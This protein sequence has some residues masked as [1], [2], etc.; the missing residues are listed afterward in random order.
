[1]T[2]K[3]WKGFSKRRNSTKQP[4]AT[5]TA[6]L[7]CRLKDNTSLHDPVLEIATNDFG[8]EY[9]YISDVGKYYFVHDV[10]SV[11]N[12]LCEYHLVEDTMA[13]E[14]TAIGATKAHIAYSSTGYNAKV[15]DPRIT[16]RNHKTILKSG[17]AT[18]GNAYRVFSPSDPGHFILTI[19]YGNDQNHPVS[20]D[21][22]TGVSISYFLSYQDIQNFAAYLSSNISAL[23]QYFNGTG[24]NCV[25]N[26][27]WVPYDLIGTK[28]S[29]HGT[30]IDGNNEIIAYYDTR[31]RIGD[32]TSN[33]DHLSLDARILSGMPRYTNTIQVPCHLQPLTANDF[34]ASEPYTTGNIYLP[35]VGTVN[36]NMSDWQDSE[37]INVEYTIEYATGNMR[38][39]LKT[40]AGIILQTHDCCVAS[41]C[42]LGQNVMTGGAGVI[43][44]IAGMVGGV[45]ALGVTAA[46]GGTGAALVPGALS[47][48]MGAANTALSANQRDVVTTGGLGGRMIQTQPYI[49][50]TEFSMNTETPTN[51][52]YIAERGGP[53]L[54]VAQISTLS[55]YIQCE[56]ASI[57]CAASALEKEEINNYLNSGFYY[58]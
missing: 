33:I 40:D 28:D 2:V 45:A 50:H 24:L 49:I 43:G 18:P 5:A 55:G 21:T 54:G 20:A 16:V 51:A 25:F 36:L 53:Y 56:G 37:Y 9:A 3:F 57:D 22:Y 58:E 10:V 11:A 34:R 47:L 29:E 32:K 4:T 44:G 14:K 52:D 8:Y 39:F 26:C 6:E 30:F 7:T 13:T 1:M 23:S 35:G 42:P 19:F 46:S 41:Q 12:G 48:I 38:Y 17:G 27:L 31:I 15:I